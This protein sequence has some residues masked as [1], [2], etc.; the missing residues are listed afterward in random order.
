ML[1][2]RRAIFAIAAWVGLVV[3]QNNVHGQPS[4]TIPGDQGAAKQGRVTSKTVFS[5]KLRLVFFMGLEGTGHHYMSQVFQE[6][7]KQ[8]DDLPLFEA[9]QAGRSMYLPWAM[10]RS[11]AEYQEAREILRNDMQTLAVAAN[12]DDMP[13][14]GT[15][16]TVQRTNPAQLQNCSEM[17]EISY[18]NA[19]GPEKSLQYPDL[20]MLAE[21]AEDEGV[22][23]RIIYLQRS[24]KALM[25]SNI[26]HRHLEG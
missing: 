3:S 9:C 23:L 26:I 4:M 17:G 5:S 15:I 21:V 12:R 11:A 19:H 1:H 13:A 22:D 16:V 10:S 8:H 2:A 14:G 18:P 6:L 20:Q 25:I 24:A 7:Y